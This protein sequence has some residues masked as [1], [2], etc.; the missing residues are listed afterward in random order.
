MNCFSPEDD[1]FTRSNS[2]ISLKLYKQAFKIKFM[3]THKPYLSLNKNARTYELGVIVS[4]AKNQTITDIRQEEVKSGNDL[5]WGVILTLSDATQLVNGPE[6]P[7]FSATIAIPLDKS[8]KYK[9]I[10]CYTRISVSEGKYGP[11]EGED[12][13]IDFGD[14]N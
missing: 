11:G 6:A 3:K 12:S 1:T 9:K 5:C 14:A 2:L 4:A 13:S 7:V 8:E 10:R